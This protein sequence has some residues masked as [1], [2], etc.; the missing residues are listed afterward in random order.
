MS[1]YNDRVWLLQL[2][3]FELSHQSTLL[4]HRVQCEMV[5]A[6]SWQS[7]LSTKRLCLHLA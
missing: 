7:F 5:C 2:D 1:M 6:D 3:L 4:A